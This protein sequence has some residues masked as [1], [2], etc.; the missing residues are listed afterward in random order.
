MRLMWQVSDTRGV[1]FLAEDIEYSKGFSDDKLI[2]RMVTMKGG[3]WGEI[4]G[5][6]G[7]DVR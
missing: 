3:S 5:L 1:A 2:E 6:L 4:S 7:E